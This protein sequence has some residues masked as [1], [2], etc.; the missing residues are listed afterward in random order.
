MVHLYCEPIIAPNVPTDIPDGQPGGGKT[1]DHPIVYTRPRLDRGSISAREL[2]I[3]K[4]RRLDEVRQRTIAEWIQKES[5]EAL[6]NSKGSAEQFEL[7]DLDELDE[8]CPEESVKITK[9]Y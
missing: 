3:K 5:W 1:S 7:D 4:T 2:V 8:I 6:F 9:Y